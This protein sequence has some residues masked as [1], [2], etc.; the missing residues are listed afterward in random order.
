[1]P[2]LKTLKDMM[3]DEC[4]ASKDCELIHS[5]ELKKEAIRWLKYIHD[6]KEHRGME[7]SA[8]WFIEQFFNINWEDFKN[9]TKQ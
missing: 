3:A 2:K 1:M 5:Y 7:V 9:D 8:K 6:P 4:P